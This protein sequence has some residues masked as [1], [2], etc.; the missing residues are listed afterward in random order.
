[1]KTEQIKVSYRDKEANKNVAL[2]TVDAPR[3]DS[4]EEA[5]AFFE[6]EE[7]EGKGVGAVLDYIHTAYDIELQRRY[8]DA[9][10]PDKPKAA[11]NVSIFKTLSQ[12]Q[13]EEL[14]KNFGLLSNVPESEEKE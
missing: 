2:G 7:G 14:L 6:S 10:R 3:F 11:S 4:L 9:H 13:Q 1:M 12:A 5:S 8:R